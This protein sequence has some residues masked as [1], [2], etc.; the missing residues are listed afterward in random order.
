MQVKI[1][2]ITRVSQAEAILQ[3]GATH[4]GFIVVPTSPR[5]Q[6]PQ[7]IRAIL[8]G[9]D[10][11]LRQQAG[12][13]G[14]FANASLEQVT[15]AVDISG[16]N[17]IQLHGA[18]PPDYCYR[19]RQ[20]FPDHRL[21]KALRIRDQ[22]DLH[23]AQTY[24]P[25]VD[26]LLLDAYRPDQLGGTGQTLDWQSLKQFQPGC[27]WWLAGGLSPDNIATAL[28]LVHPD[29]IDLSSG[30]E[31]SPGIKDLNRVQELFE[32]LRPWRI[33]SG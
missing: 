13:V 3:M 4:L 32:Q 25:V 19:L 11:T 22:S 1:C 27:A 30:V 24:A 26:M 10:S 28:D 23:Q 12:L 8:D 6:S 33:A 14:V 18:E 5:Y 2:G 9:L 20:D 16:I 21:I 15:A 29:G 17:G 7:Q 31:Q